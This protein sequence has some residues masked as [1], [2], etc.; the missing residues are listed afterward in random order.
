[1]YETYTLLLSTGSTVHKWYTFRETNIYLAS[2]NKVS[3]AFLLGGSKVST[4]YDT[5]EDYCATEYI[6]RA[7]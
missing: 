1:V 5:S 3:S 4:R 7:S 2:Q 6:S